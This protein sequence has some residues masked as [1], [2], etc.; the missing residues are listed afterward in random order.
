METTFDDV[1]ENIDRLSIS[2]QELVIDIVNKR[3]RDFKRSEI[4]R[5]V[6]EGRADYIAGK[7]KR[8]TLEDLMK[9]LESD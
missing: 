7:V 6:L 4:I 8:G 1:M 3:I 5:D 2:E 9:D